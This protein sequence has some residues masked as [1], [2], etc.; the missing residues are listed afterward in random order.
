LSDKLQIY[1]ASAGSGK[2]S[3]LAT[4]YIKLAL[5][6]PEA[7]KSILAVTFTNKATQEMKER[8]ITLLYNLT[9]L[10]YKNHEIA[11]LLTQLGNFENQNQFKELSSAV[12]KN[13]L[14]NYSHFSVSTIDSFFT[15]ILQSF[16]REMGISYGYQI[17]LE[18]QK[19]LDEVIERLLDKLKKGMELTEYLI[20]YLNYKI[21]N[22][23][24]WDIERDLK[25]LSRELLNE[26]YWEKRFSRQYG[27][28][29]VEKQKE[30]VRSFIKE[31]S[32]YK[33][34]FI[35]KIQKIGIQINTLFEKNQLSENLFYNKTKGLAPYLKALANISVENFRMPS[36]AQMCAIENP[37]QKFFTDKTQI[38]D[39]VKEELKAILSE[40]NRLFNK[41]RGIQIYKSIEVILQ[42]FF[43]VEIFKD[44]LEELIYYRVDNRILLQADIN[45][46]LRKII[47]TATSPFI[48]EKAALSY[49]HYL[50]DEFQDTSLFQ[51]HNFKPLIENSLSENHECL[52]VGDVKQA[53]YRWRNGDMKLLG[54]EILNDLAPFLSNKQILNLKNNYRSFRNIVEFN[55]L[56]FSKL[57]EFLELKSGL[58]KET[59]SPVLVSQ[60]VPEDK[61]GGYVN[62]LFITKPKEKV[63]DYDI[64][65]K[66]EENLLRVIDEILRDG[67]D[68]KDIVILVRRNITGNNI[69]E[70]LVKN[71]KLVTSSD[72]LLIYKSSK[73]KLIIGVLKLLCDEENKLLLF[74]VLYEYLLNT[75]GIFDTALYELPVDYKKFVQQLKSILPT[76]LFS[77]SNNFSL[78]PLLNSLSLYEVCEL[79]VQIFKLD[80]ADPYILKFL[81][82]VDKYMKKYEGDIVSF[83][84]W[85]EEN[86]KNISIAFPEEANA[87]R[88]M[89]IHSV[90]GLSGRVVIIPYTDWELGLDGGKD[91]I[92]VSSNE[93]LVGKYSPYYVRAAKELEKTIFNEDYIEEQQL[94]H[95]D[96]I[97]L[98]YVAFTRAIERLYVFVQSKNNSIQNINK[99]TT[100]VNNLPSLIE[101]VVR[102]LGIGKFSYTYD[103]ELFEYGE[104]NIKSSE[105]QKKITKSTDLQYHNLEKFI[106]LNYF[107]RIV[108]KPYKE[109]LQ[110]FLN[111]DN[112]QLLDR[113]IILHKILSKLYYQDELD[114]L[115]DNLIVE[116]NSITDIEILKKSILAL[117]NNP[118]LKTYFSRDWKIL[119]ESEII[120]SNLEILRP[121]RIVYND[122]IAVVIDYKT[123]LQREEDVE[124]INRYGEILL[125]MGYKIV[126]KYLV[127]FDFENEISPIKVREL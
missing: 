9:E 72:S 16:A 75:K 44:I 47:S 81:E 92:W 97:N 96:N 89:T 13:I 14:H 103:V 24:S 66:V 8:I 4:F 21:D 38:D 54:G 124:Q 61:L 118:S 59:Y 73:I 74:E 106:S 22:S 104:K 5:R 62:I 53:I 34:E 98:L 109:D 121:D 26:T 1:T 48:L 33:K 57:P 7:F 95:L 70:L 125:K 42:N 20:D 107:N 49:K 101:N 36:D 45:L 105:T 127:Y 15:K 25:K 83:L 32:N 126:K 68:L 120:T 86:K 91:Y 80:S 90:K 23:G 102:N 123:G 35:N 2:T 3:K 6:H 63:E 40:L 30:S 82:T 46:I 12:L 41:E 111:S 84:M 69:A 29:F 119:T 116:E 43:L 27:E 31:L 55:N 79:I 18:Q 17:E 71:G 60:K 113:G 77:E 117:V 64:K 114:N 100:P 10:P 108:T 39:K 51:W 50:F 112:R 56:F 67:Y 99:S 85:W 19:V 87:I 65:E 93:E 58:F 110:Q 76:E 37:E 28:R 11:S 94:K 122:D 115:F 52:I 78:N 88:I